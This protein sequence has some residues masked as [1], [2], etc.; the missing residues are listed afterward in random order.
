MKSLRPILI[1]AALWAALTILFTSAVWTSETIDRSHIRPNALTSLRLIDSEGI[2]PRFGESNKTQKDNFS[3]ALMI[4]TAAAPLSPNSDALSRAL[5][6]ESC[7]GDSVQDIAATSIKSITQDRKQAY[8]PYG[9]YWHGYLTT[10][11]PLLCIADLHTIRTLN[12][13]LLYLLALIAAALIWRRLGAATAA[14]FLLSLL[15]V[16][17][18]RVP[19]T[20]MFCTCFIIM[21]LSCIAVTAIPQKHL[22]PA[23]LSYLFF[24]IG[25]LTS[26]F[27]LLSTPLL[28]FAFPAAIALLR[29]RQMPD[30]R[31]LLV[32]GCAWLA[33]YAG[34]WATKWLLVYLFTDF[35]IWSDALNS[36]KYRSGAIGDADTFTFRYALTRL[37]Q[38]F[39]ICTIAAAVALI[40]KRGKR[41]MKYITLPL[42]G[43]LPAL[44]MLALQNHSIG[45]FWFT[46]RIIAICFFCN[47]L[48][49][50]LTF[51][52]PNQPQRHPATKQ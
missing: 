21:L 2:Y 35:N 12:Y 20:L 3:D 19:D 33:G 48:Y 47:T 13:I 11:R 16:G 7:F 30:F 5:L 1:I 42:I 32:C 40:L 52:N 49:F 23:K 10:L 38:I 22:T 34:L 43:W 14:I 36:V 44:W 27:D 4:S 28:T 50:Y 15:A 8:A 45:H 39:A 46:W 24:T 26:F 6:A 31:A 51:S 29:R 41:L 37:A 25:A 9:R 17:F 18:A